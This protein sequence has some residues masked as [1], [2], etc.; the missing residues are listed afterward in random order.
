[1][2]QGSLDMNGALVELHHSSSRPGLEWEL[3]I[4]T[5]TACTPLDVSVQ[6]RD[7]VM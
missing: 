2:L 1:M 4:V 5:S 6:S 3:R 7:M